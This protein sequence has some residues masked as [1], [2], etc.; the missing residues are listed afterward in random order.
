[1]KSF[2]HQTGDFAIWKDKYG[3]GKDSSELWN[4]YITGEIKYSYSVNNILGDIDSFSRC[5]NYKTKETPIEKEIDVG[6]D[7]QKINIGTS[8]G[9]T[10]TYTETKEFYETDENS[11]APLDEIINIERTYS[12]VEDKNPEGKVTGTVETWLIKESNKTV[13]ENGV[14]KL[15]LQNLK[16]AKAFNTESTGNAFG[17]G[18]GGCNLFIFTKFFFKTGNIIFHLLLG[19]LSKDTS[20]PI[21]IYISINKKRNLLYLSLVI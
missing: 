12:Y 6:G 7:T 14:F 11:I 21:K 5:L 18:I 3:S 15:M 8:Y 17:S 13:V 4:Q 19:N 9:K 16:T 10:W 2:S 20:Y 1:M